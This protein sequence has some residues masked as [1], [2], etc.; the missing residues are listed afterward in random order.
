MIKYLKLK[1]NL[2]KL[3]LFLKKISN[4]FNLCD[5]VV[6][7]TRRSLEEVLKIN[8]KNNN[9]IKWIHL[10]GAGV[11]KYLYLKNFNNLVYTNGKIIQGIQ[12]LIMQWVL[13]LA[14]SRNINLI[15]KYGQ[16]TK[17]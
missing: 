13:L 8:F 17:I 12:V 10:P 3:I 7:I 6:G 4:K 11:D 2:K 16:N 1:R 9:K 15:L 5:A 14:L